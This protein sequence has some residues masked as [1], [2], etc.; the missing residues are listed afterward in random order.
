MSPARRSITA[1]IGKRVRAVEGAQS[2]IAYQLGVPE[3]TVCHWFSETSE[4]RYHMPVDALPV[5]A[6]EIGVE[7]Y[8]P[9]VSENGLDQP[10]P[11]RRPTTNPG[12]LSSAMLAVY[13]EI[14]EA[15]AELEA[16]GTDVS[17]DEGERIYREAEEARA[18]LDAFMA[19]CPRKAVRS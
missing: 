18:A 14:G 17:E 5:V 1:M 15:S 13:R 3:S 11:R 9:I 12:S 6:A 19:R 7:V 4:R 10:L 8:G 2:R 16:A